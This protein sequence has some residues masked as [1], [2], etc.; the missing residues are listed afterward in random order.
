MK[1]KRKLGI[2]MDH[3]VAHLM[4][5]S[6]GPF[7]VTT[8]ESDLEKLIKKTPVKSLSMHRKAQDLQLR[9]YGKIS[10]AIQDFYHVVLFGP[11]S[12]K[13]ELFELLSEDENFMR[14]KIEI[15]E[16]DEMN[17]RQKHEFMRRYFSTP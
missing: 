16:T 8:I 13:V 2:W 11:T 4:E 9:Y 5:I 15:M 10:Q 1:R 7:E 14:H 6:Q 12:A 17:L 3:S